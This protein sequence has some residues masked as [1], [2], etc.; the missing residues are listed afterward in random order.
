LKPENVV[1]SLTDEE[2]REIKEKGVLT[3]T[4]MYNKKSELIKRSVHGA[5]NILTQRNNSTQENPSKADQ[6]Q[7][8]VDLTERSC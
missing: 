2:L 6:N 1:I 7:T 8:E 5:A 4:K 3:T